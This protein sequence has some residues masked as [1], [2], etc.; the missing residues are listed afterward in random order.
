[1]IKENEIR[2]GNYYNRTE[3]LRKDI[4]G[5][6][7]FDSSDWY[8]IGECMDYLE[9]YDPIPLTEEIL[10]KCRVKFGIKLQD[11]VKGKHQFVEIGILNGLFSEEGIFYYGL[12]TKLKHLHQLQN[13]YFALTS[14]ELN[15]N[16]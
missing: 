8:A 4:I 9:S 5:I 11:F 1:M 14:E 16:L 2:V 15:V 10:L 3:T 12:Q 6:V 7:K 13:L